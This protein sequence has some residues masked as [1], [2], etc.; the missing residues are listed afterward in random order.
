MEELCPSSVRT[1][2]SEHYPLTSATMSQTH[3]HKIKNSIF[4]QK[5]LPPPSLTI[6]EN[7]YLLSLQ[8][9]NLTVMLLSP[10]SPISTKSLN[11]RDSVLLPL[12]Y[13]KATSVHSLWSLI[14]D[15]ETLITAHLLCPLT[16]SKH[17]CLMYLL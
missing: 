11:P 5:N 10:S 1:L 4:L 3:T 2:T 7:Q 17:Q 9:E 14:Y 16:Y 15:C 6:S 8:T 13:F 12:F